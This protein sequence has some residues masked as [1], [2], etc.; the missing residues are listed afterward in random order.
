V[1]AAQQ[2]QIVSIHLA[3]KAPQAARL[4]LM[5]CAQMEAMV[6][7]SPAVL[8]AKIQQYPAMFFDQF[9]AQLLVQEALSL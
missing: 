7:V 4:F 6:A 2:E 3:L 8:V 5:C 1:L 9:S